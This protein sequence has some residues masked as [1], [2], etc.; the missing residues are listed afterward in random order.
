MSK[1]SV[2]VIGGGAGGLCA[3]IAAAEQGAEVT[4]YERS[5]RL[6][7]KLLK[8]GNGRCNLSH[9]PVLPTDYNHPDFVSGV[10]AHWDN[11]AILQ[12]FRSL[13]LYTVKD[14]EGRC[15]P[16]SDTASSVL[17]VLRLRCGAL[18]VEEVCS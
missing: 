12:F 10:L 8:T 9:D 14:S 17:D 18:G 13:G 7:K 6:G 3:A 16:L 5:N 1:Q 4:L 2:A 15:Y 11:A